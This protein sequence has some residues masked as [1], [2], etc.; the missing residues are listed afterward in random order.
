MIS[1]YE[2]KEAVKK[3]NMAIGFLKKYGIIVDYS[4]E[5]NYFIV[6]I[7]QEVVNDKEILEVI[8]EQSFDIGC[9]LLSEEDTVYREYKITSKPNESAN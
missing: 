2:I 1:K 7:P 9:A 5:E 8:R 3:G 6:L 4:K